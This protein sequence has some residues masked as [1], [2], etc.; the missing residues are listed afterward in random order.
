MEFDVTEIDDILLVQ[1][2]YANAKAFGMGF[3]QN[4]IMDIKGEKNTQ[5]L[6]KE[7]ARQL[8]NENTEKSYLSLGSETWYLDYVNGRAVK[9]RLDWKN[10]RKII[11]TDAF[12]YRHGKYAALKILLKTFLYDEFSIVKKGYSETLGLPEWKNDFK[13]YSSEENKMY[14][15]ILKQTIKKTEHYGTR[16]YLKKPS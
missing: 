7:T 4:S 12:D 10:G 15:L 6:D 13:D 14:Q 11:F 1:A 2:F 5:G 9:L 16:Y 3:V 8:I